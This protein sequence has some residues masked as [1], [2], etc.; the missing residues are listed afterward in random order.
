MYIDPVF[1]DILRK[2]IPSM[3]LG[4]SMHEVLERHGWTARANHRHVF[5]HRDHRGHEIIV[6]TQHNN[7]THF[8][9]RN[10]GH[11]SGDGAESLDRHLAAQA[12]TRRRRN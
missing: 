6:N 12:W 8:G 10:N 2:A 11:G 9:Q 7:W 1:V 5:E 3:P 4:A